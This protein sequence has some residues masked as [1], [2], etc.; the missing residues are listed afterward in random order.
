MRSV[1]C[2]LLTSLFTL[3]AWAQTARLTLEDIWL[4]GTF[5]QEYV[6]G[7]RSMND[8]LHYTALE[9]T[10]QGQ[11]ILKYSYATGEVVDTLFHTANHSEPKAISG[12]RLSDDEKQLLLQADAEA[13]YRYSTRELNYVYDLG[14]G[15]LHSISQ[16]GKQSFATFNPAGTQVAYVRNNNLYI[17]DIASQQTTTV[18][19]DG[20]PNTIINGGTDWVYEEEFAFDK[21]FAW[22]PDGKRIAFYKFNEAQVKQFNMPIYAGQLYPS[23]YEFKYPKAGEANSVVSIHVYNLETGETQEITRTIK[24]D[25]EYIPRIQWIDAE[26]LAMQWMN[27]HQS[28]LDIRTYHTGTSE[29]KSIYQESSDTY[30][31]VPDS[32]TFLPKRDLL[33]LTSEQS[34]FNHIYQVNMSSATATP[35]TSGEW[36]VTDFYGVDSKGM[37]YY[38][39]AEETPIK[40]DIYSIR[41][42]GK[43]KK[44][45]TEKVGWNEAQF[46]TGMKYFINTWSN[47]ETPPQYTL[48]NSKGKLIRTLK[49]NAKLQE[50]LAGYGL[51]EKEFF[52][53]Q[54]EQGHE[55]NCWMI[56]PQSLRPDRKY[57]VLISIYG[58]PGSQTVEDSWGG[59]N[60]LWHQYLAQQGYIVVSVDNRGT[61]A[62][63]TAFKK[64]TYKQLGKYELEDYIETAKYL[65]KQNYIDG[66]RIGM[67]G[68]SYGGYMS[69]LAITKGYEWFKAAIAV[70]PVTTW[71]YYDNIYTERYM[72]T[73]QE[74]ASG[75]DD[76]SPINFVDLMQGNYLLIHG[77]ADDNVHFQNTV[78]MVNSLV[79]AGKQFD[80]F[81]YP[82]RNHGIYG[83]NTRYHI[84]QKMSQWLRENL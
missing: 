84:Y 64:A 68:W 49:D 73:P 22:S 59:S 5:R 62:R 76:N 31:D 20:A 51:S 46:S 17:T 25:R 27:R 19:E 36:D 61:G 71:R 74:N 82:D 78:E 43:S 47:A 14:S 35:V 77:T 3:P 29:I 52:S 45:L 21:A 67:W 16:Q 9:R 37:V 12:Y 10:K 54:T 8:G 53:F 28:K 15:S 23:D 81:F 1:A 79:S 44:K 32:W 56:K 41:L 63:G 48:H 72:Q 66:S 83:G 4:T 2:I 69:S 50:K 39:S 24:D 60:H 11:L 57:P 70:A 38:A 6:W 42:N 65:S 80:M 34:G 26:R 30:I 58:G 40:R 7:L 75:Y 33:V 13:I 55:L 18:T